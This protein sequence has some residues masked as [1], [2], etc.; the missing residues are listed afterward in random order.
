[1]VEVPFILTLIK[2]NFEISK[3]NHCAYSMQKPSG[4][5]SVID[6]GYINP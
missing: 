2:I 4:I 3:S 1:M 6:A 5:K